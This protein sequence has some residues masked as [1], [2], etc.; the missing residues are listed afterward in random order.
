MLPEERFF[1]RGWGLDDEQQRLLEELLTTLNHA[2][3]KVFGKI[4]AGVTSRSKN[5]S[6]KEL[7]LAGGLDNGAF[8]AHQESMIARSA[9]GV[10]K[11]AA[12]NAKVYE[13]K[14]QE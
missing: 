9:Q 4:N 8:T 5:G 6:P 7:I 10:Y 12:A 11:L 2:Q 13:Q 3:R 14:L 1:K